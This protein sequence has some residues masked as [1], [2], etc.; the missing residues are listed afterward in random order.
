MCKSFWQF[1]GP[2]L[3]TW[4]FEKFPCRR[5]FLYHSEMLL[6]S[7]VKILS[8][9]LLDFAT[10]N[11][12]WSS[13]SKNSLFLSVEKCKLFW[14]TFQRRGPKANP[15]GQP[16][17]VECQS[18]VVS[19]QETCSYV[20]LYRETLCQ[21][22]K[23]K[24]QQLPQEVVERFAQENEALKTTVY[25]VGA[26]VLCLL[27]AAFFL[28]WVVLL[29]PGAEPT[30]LKFFYAFKPWIRTFG[31]LNLL[32][33]PLIYCWRQQEM[34]KFVFEISSSPSCTPCDLN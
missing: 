17:V 26:V 8:T 25:V 10:E 18:L 14:K 21:C 3:V 23:I 11:S 28:L 27:P 12:W 24:S 29:P 1:F 4:Y 20:I 31:R 22:K 19:W 13:A 2:R 30:K 9:S 7:L 6:P 5:L 32:L 33:N 16:L 34:R 15:W